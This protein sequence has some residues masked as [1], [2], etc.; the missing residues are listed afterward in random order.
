M[1]IRFPS[2]NTKKLSLLILEMSPKITVHC[3]LASIERLSSVNQTSSFKFVRFG[4]RIIHRI[5]RQLGSTV[6]CQ[7][8]AGRIVDLCYQ[9]RQ[10]LPILNHRNAVVC[11]CDCNSYDHELIVPGPLQFDGKI[12]PK[13][14][15]LQLTGSYCYQ[16]QKLL[17]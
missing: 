2:K 8:C 9:N 6:F 3:I 13:C 4:R 17:F 14:E 10:N 7:G 16:R 12:T 15:P 5:D 11:R 1:N